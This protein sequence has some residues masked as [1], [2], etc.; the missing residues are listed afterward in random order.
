MGASVVYGLLSSDGNGFR[1]GLQNLLE[2]NGTQTTMVGTQ[3]SGNMS[4]N[5]HEAYQAM[6]I[7]GFNNKTYHSGAYDLDANVI[8]VLIGT[9]DCWYV[10]NGNSSAAD[11]RLESGIGAALRFGNLLGS[12]KTHAPEALVLASTLP[13]NKNQWEDRCIQGFNS[14]LPAVV[15]DAVEKGQQVRLVDMYDV[16]PLDEFH[17]DGTHPTD[18][19]YQ[20]MAHQWY[21]AV[22]NATEH[23]CVERSA[24]TT[25]PSPA[26]GSGTVAGV[27]SSNSSSQ[28]DQSA[29]PSKSAAAASSP[30]SHLMISLLVPLLTMWM[31]VVSAHE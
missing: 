14:H 15:Q 3:R 8:L 11:P 30:S 1:L 21:S 17:S 23:L 18:H 25:E 24:N 31:L 4:D 6:T 19:G 10:K 13:R 7:D 27:A 26:P 12:I 2:A 29:S 5:H 22:S 9:N 16:V 28:N 20:L